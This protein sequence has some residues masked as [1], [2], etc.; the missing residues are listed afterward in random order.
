MADTE[1][2]IEH[3]RS[4][5][6]VTVGVVGALTFVFAAVAIF[7]YLSIRRQLRVFLEV[8]RTIADVSEG[9]LTRTIMTNEVGEAGRIAAALDSMIFR[10]RATLEKTAETSG[11]LRASSASLQD[12][13]HEMAAIAR[14][15]LKQANNA[16]RAAGSVSES[17]STVATASEEMTASI[18]E[19]AMRTAKSSQVAAN[20]ANAASEASRTITKLGSSTE[21][22]GQVVKVITSI[23]EQTNLLAL[24]ATIEAARAGEAGKG[25]AVVASEVKELAKQTARATE[26]IRARIEAIQTDTRG[27]VAAMSE[28]A[29]VN[30]EINAIQTNVASSVEEQAATMDQISQNASEAAHSTTQIAASIVSVCEAEE[31]ASEAAAGTV[32]AA[33]QL[34]QLADTLNE[35]LAHF[36]LVD[37]L[38][39]AETASYPTGSACTWRPAAPRR[40]RVTA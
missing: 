18:S 35:I 21:E 12:V 23:A 22:I 38:E 40:K 27:A 37:D 8:E 13:S 16:S 36:R 2:L 33:Q 5:L 1:V 15:T 25:F 20:A 19:I 17:V 3:R 10:L 29:R 4:Q 26:D 24:N 34:A 31:K 7:V 11:T 30:E 6:L 9:D 28:I 14:R 32:E 39:L